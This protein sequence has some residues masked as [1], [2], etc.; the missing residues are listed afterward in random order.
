MGKKIK[1]KRE[2]PVYLTQDGD[3]PNNLFLLMVTVPFLIIGVLII[4]IPFKIYDEIFGNY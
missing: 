2:T 3:L 4:W 1:K